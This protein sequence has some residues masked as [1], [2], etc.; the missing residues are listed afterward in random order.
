MSIFPIDIVQ[1]KT[2]G[3]YV[4]IQIKAQFRGSLLKSKLLM[5]QNEFFDERYLCHVMRPLPGR[6]ALWRKRVLVLEEF[7][8]MLTFY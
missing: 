5:Q 4:L 3:S 6:S 8:Y 2:F 1:Y 7:R